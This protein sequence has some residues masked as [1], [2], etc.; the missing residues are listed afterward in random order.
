LAQIAWGKKMDPYSIRESNGMATLIHPHWEALTAATIKALHL[1]EGL[2][3]IDQFYLAGDTGLAL[4]LGHCF[5]ID[6]DLFSTEV[7][8]VGP[9]QRDAL[10]IKLDQPSLAITYD[11]DGAFAVVWQGVGIFSA[12]RQFH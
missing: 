12:Y 3:F 5:S 7:T 10:R 9:D 2:P 6:I 8:A 4:H 11:K 1:V